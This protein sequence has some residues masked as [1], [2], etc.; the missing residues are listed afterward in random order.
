MEIF[1]VEN[2]YREKSEP[3]YHF[4]LRFNDF[5]IGVV[6]ADFHQS[7]IVDCPHDFSLFAHGEVRCRAGDKIRNKRLCPGNKVRPHRQ[8]GFNGLGRSGERLLDD[9]IGLAILDVEFYTILE[10]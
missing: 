10:E 1:R 2:T 9:T 6:R 7:V 5:G 3:L 4:S 8:I